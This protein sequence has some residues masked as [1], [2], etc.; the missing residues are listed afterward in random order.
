MEQSDGVS[1]D[2]L[3]AWKTQP[4]VKATGIVTNAATMK[5]RRRWRR[6]K[7]TDNKE[8]QIKIGKGK[9]KVFCVF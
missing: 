4:M 1:A 3:T 2:L 6:N 5:K 8:M 9:G 7:T